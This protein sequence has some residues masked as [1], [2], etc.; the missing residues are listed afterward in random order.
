VLKAAARRMRVT[1]SIGCGVLVLAMLAAV[2][3]VVAGVVVLTTNRCS[4]RQFPP[5]GCPVASIDPPGATLGW[6]LIFGGVAAVLVV[7]LIGMGV[8]LSLKGR[9]KQKAREDGQEAARRNDEEQR[10][11]QH[12]MSQ[13][14]AEFGAQGYTGEAAD[15]LARKRLRDKGPTQRVWLPMDIENERQEAERQQQAAAVTQEKEREEADRQRKIHAGEL[16]RCPRCQ[17]YAPVSQGVILAHRA[18]S[19]TTPCDGEGTILRDA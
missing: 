14:L 19:H 5:A 3:L 9:G 1:Y 11:M 2:G 18:S 16:A 6:H 17:E 13:Y 10:R 15:A 4:F 12:A 8:V 7:L